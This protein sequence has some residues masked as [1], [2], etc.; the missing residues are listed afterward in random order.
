MCAKYNIAVLIDGDNAQAKLLPKILTEVS[1]YGRP[2]IRRIYAD[3]TSPLRSCWKEPIHRFGLKPVQQFAY[4]V[5]K[6]STDIALI[7]DA[8]DILHARNGAVS[9]NGI[10]GVCIVSSDS[11]FTGLAM[12]F[13]EDGLFVMGVGKRATV[14]A[15]V[16]SC[17][18]FV[19]IEDLSSSTVQTVTELPKAPA[20]HPP[21]PAPAKAPTV[22]QKVVAKPAAKTAQNKTSATPVAAVRS[23][24]DVGMIDRAF[25][26]ACNGK[27]E[28]DLSKVG[29]SIRQLDKNFTLKQ[30]G[31]KTL[32]GLFDTLN[33]YTVVKAAGGR[34]SVCKKNAGG[35]Q[36]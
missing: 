27:S 19:F 23:K 10:G 14:A 33:H 34:H 13:R 24:L 16:N 29:N 32:K 7:I 35:T 5:G 4:T 25:T 30:Y 21:K 3:W 6:N 31:F 2:T 28:V 1:K 26:A 17:D 12:R 18:V 20:P 8:M 11:D 36:R 22:K 15:F 9:K